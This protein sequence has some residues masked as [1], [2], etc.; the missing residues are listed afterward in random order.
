MSAKN[1]MTSRANSSPYPSTRWLGVVA[2]ALTAALTGCGEKKE[3]PALQTAAK[4]NK[5]EITVSQIQQVLNAQRAAVPAAQAASA[6]SLALERLIDQELALQKASDQKL[7]R[8][9]RVMQQ[10]EAARREIIARAYVEKIGDGAPKATPAEV[11]AYYEKHPALFSNRRI[12]NLQEVDI[13]FPPEKQD[14]VKAALQAAKTFPIFL[15][16][17]KGNGFVFKGTEGV[18]SAEQLPLASVDQF[19][20]LK[21][22]QAVFVARPTGAR[23]IHLVGS[24]SQP[25]NLDRATPA[26]EQ[27]LLNERKRK[28]IADDIRALRGA[29]KIDYVGNYAANKPPPL[30]APQ[31]EGPPVMSIA[32]SAP[33]PIDAAPQVEL[34]PRDAAS[35]AKP[36]GDILEK[37]LKGMK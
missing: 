22:G 30:P 25:V 13:E 2:L 31:P 35:A 11:K 10:I 8:E 26:I 21:D 16:Y 28:L 20:A 1:L 15:E 29:A 6:E 23:V 18:R 4:V 32:G 7:D 9:P 34:A 24:R 5:E 27:Y 19:A 37:G 33:P 17:L 12:Y 14:A 36:S 3:K